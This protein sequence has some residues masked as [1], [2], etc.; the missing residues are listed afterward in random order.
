MRALAPPTVR[1]SLR[2]ALLAAAG[3]SAAACSRTPAPARAEIRAVPPARHDELVIRRGTFVRT[4]LMFG[5][6][7]AVAA[8][9]LKVPRVPQGRAV[10]RWLVADGSPVKKGEVI[11]ELDNATFASQA[12]D[13]QITVAQAEIDLKRQEWQNGLA[14]TDRTL[15][16]ARK[17]AAF[18]RAEVDADVPEGILPRREHL[19]KQLALSRARADLDRAEEALAAQ[20]KLGAEDLR[21]KQIALDKANYDLALARKS[22]RELTLRAPIDGVVFVNKHREGR[23]LQVGDD[24]FMGATVARMPDLAQIR[25]KAWLSDVDEG[26]VAIGA[27]ASVIVDAYP[28]RTWPGRIDAIAPIAREPMPRSP[29][30]FFDVT[31]KLESDAR[32]ELRPGMST[33]VEVPLERLDDQLLAPRAAL[34]F[35]EQPTVRS[36]DGREIAVAIVGCTA[37]ACA[38]AG[39]PPE[40]TRLAPRGD[41]TAE[42]RP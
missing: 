4:H 37:Q 24:V 8:A 15:D 39:G 35:G 14:E 19:E 26:R 10:L 20:K 9:E 1:A 18:R 22:I 11:A 13:L 12:Q 32:A 5:E 28:D 34:R 40:G 6:V 25:V 2:V 31:I 42:P 36:A 21:I 3:L 41:R 23:L 17:R 7:D 16:I 30:R 38:I 29:R 27:P 33:R